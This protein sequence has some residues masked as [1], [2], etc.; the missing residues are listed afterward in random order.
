MEVPSDETLQRMTWTPKSITT[1]PYVKKR[2]DEYFVGDK[3]VILKDEDT[4][5]VL[6]ALYKDVPPSTGYL[7]FFSHIK[8]KT[9]GLRRRIVQEFLAKQTGNQLYR[10]VRQRHEVRP[11]VVKK[12]GVYW[13]SDFKVMPRGIGGG[14]SGW[15]SFMTFI[16]SNSKYI[17]IYP[18]RTETSA[19]I[20][21]VIRKWLNDLEDLGDRYVERVK[22]L[23]TDRGP[24]F[25]SD[26][27]TAF[28]KEHEIR[29]VLSKSYTPQSQGIVERSH[30]TVARY[31]TSFSHGKIG[32]W[33]KHIDDVTNYINNTFHRV[34]GNKTP[35]EVFEGETDPVINQRLQKEAD[36]RAIN[37]ARLTNLQ[38]GD[39]VRISLR[40]SGT[41][42]EK[43]AI[44]GG[45][46]KSHQ[47]NWS[48]EVYRV[49][50]ASRGYYQLRGKEGIYHRADL[51]R[52]P[53]PSALE[54][55]DE[56]EEEKE[57]DA[58]SPPS[59]R[60]R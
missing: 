44:K 14:R 47:Q 52:I 23:H 57:E 39:H 58:S 19:E 20:V 60:R 32:T 10:E 29:Q 34:L 5:P 22:V 26:E 36:S 6:K 42:K 51:L 56:E 24:G 37:N 18:A 45:M 27:T 30:S 43:G 53:P 59:A 21:R 25:T 7:A 35:K 31:L 16:D 54:D 17:M 1:R 55:V 33:P 15:T 38:V 40:A 3:Q 8:S 48:N 9:I 11:I 49:I 50:R 28:L 2:G 46:R 12:P 13:T 41:T 4:T